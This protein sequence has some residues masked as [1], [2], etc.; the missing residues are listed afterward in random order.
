V[1]LVTPSPSAT[2]APVD[3]RCPPFA[4]DETAVLGP[5]FHREYFEH[6][7]S[8]AIAAR[9]VQGLEA[10]YAGGQNVDRCG[11]F[12]DRGLATALL[13]DPH[14]GAADRR[15]RLIDG[16]LVMR[17]ASEG[18]YDLRMT[19]PRVP[20]DIIFDIAD[21]A[22]I[23]DPATG[24]VVVKRDP[25]RVGLGLT[26]AFDGHRWLVDEV[27][28]ISTD[29]VAWSRLP[30]ALPPGLPCSGFHQDA[31]GA[32]YDD[33]EERVWCTNH[34]RGTLLRRDAEY[35]LITRY[36]CNGR[37]TILTIGRPLGAP[38]DPLDRWEY[39]RDP[40]GTFRTNGWLAGRYNGD[41]QLPVDAEDTGWGNG[42]VDL[43]ISPSNLD[44]GIY[45][46]RGR[47]VERWGRAGPSWGVID[48][49]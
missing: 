29:N 4:F 8:T 16:D 12:T 35:A 22:R 14:L 37:S 30:E 39:V 47:T 24:F 21:G 11:L 38:L 33:R 19:P 7:E 20:L 36:P 27:R 40:D 13:F 23:T 17:M 34:G 43:W 32:A 46:V 42:N 2:P 31:P 28:R 6:D 44:R 45:L 9:F 48:C 25:E 1:A 41:T 3:V 10:L 5:A 15:E 18:T 26:F 49:N